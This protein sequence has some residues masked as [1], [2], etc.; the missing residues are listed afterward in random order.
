MQRPSVEIDSFDKYMW[1]IIAGLIVSIGVLTVFGDQVGL[2]VQSVSPMVSATDVSIIDDIRIQFDQPMDRSSVQGLFSIDPNIKGAFRWNNETLIFDPQIPLQS[3]HVYTVTLQAG[4]KS[5]AGREL[6]ESYR[7]QFLTKQPT[8]YFLSPYSGFDRRLWAVSLAD[9]IPREIYTADY[10]IF[11]F[12]PSPDGTQLALTVYGQEN[13]TADIWLINADGSNPRQLTNCPPGA[14]SR[15]VWSPDGRYIAYENQPH[16][17]RNILGPP[18]IWLLDLTTGD[19]NPVFADDQ[20]LGYGVR[21][22]PDGRHLSFYDAA[23]NSIRILNLTTQNVHIIETQQSEYWTFSLDSD[24]LIYTNSRRE[25]Q[26]FYT[27]LWRADLVSD[28]IR[29]LFET[30]EEDQAP[31]WSPD[32]RWI[33]FARRIIDPQFESTWQ[34]MLY[35][36]VSGDIRRITDDERYSNLSYIWHPS[37]EML[38]VHRFDRE[39]NYPT[40]E[41]WFYDMATEELNLFAQDASDAAWGDY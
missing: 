19:N 40:A 4:A 14:C 10:G 1:S 5:V 18:R 29:P 22:S 2:E 15:P 11:D 12:Q 17:E 38:L 33:A 3:N 20:I 41:I 6:K 21:W 8:I 39:S 7:W 24:A 28:N 35:D 16:I 26:F 27:E 13:R 25:S 37:G 31:I 36:T 9:G 34:L 23:V 30:T 32:G